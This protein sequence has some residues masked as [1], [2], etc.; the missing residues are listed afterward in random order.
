MSKLTQVEPTARLA[1]VFNNIGGHPVGSIVER[2]S[3]GNWKLHDKSN[4]R[5]YSHSLESSLLWIDE[6]VG[7]KWIKTTDNGTRNKGDIT[8]ITKL[9]NNITTQGVRYF[10]SSSSTYEYFFKHFKP[11]K[12]PTEEEHTD[13][14]TKC[15]FGDELFSSGTFSIDDNNW[16]QTKE[17]EMKTDIKIEVNGESIDLC[18]HEAIH[19]KPKTDFEKRMPY[20]MVVYTTSGAYEQIKYSKTANASRKRAKK[21]LQ[22]PENLGKTIT[23]HKKIKTLTTNVPVIEFK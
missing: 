2:G 15:R 8:T 22:L 11:Y 12:E 1:V 19:T 17:T 18:K 6:L 13:K 23:L 3:F 5:G 14:T 7:S 4:D 21:F 10:N 20:A 9:Y 16:N